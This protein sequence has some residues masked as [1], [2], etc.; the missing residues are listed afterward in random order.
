MLLIDCYNVLHCAMPP[1]LA[2]LDVERLCRALA[3]THW[4]KTG[5]VT[6]V[7]DGRPNPLGTPTSPVPEVG[8]VYSGGSSGGGR[9]ADDVIIARIAASSHP[10]RLTVVSSDREIRAAAHHR[11]C[12]SWSS[13]DFLSRLCGQL[14]RQARHQTKTKPRPKQPKPLGVGRTALDGVPAEQ[15]LRWL[16]EMGVPDVPDPTFRDLAQTPSIRPEQLGIDLHLQDALDHLA[17]LDMDDVMRRF[18]KS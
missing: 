12:A 17:D 2:G 9:S 14:R 5:G 13:E 4:V 3:K 6:V 11:R 16:R 15:A 1:M 18:G 8:L 7:A 10:R